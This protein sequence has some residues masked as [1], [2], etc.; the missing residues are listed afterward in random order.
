MGS[1]DEAAT[2]A[3]TSTFKAKVAA[4][5][6][7]KQGRGSMPFVAPLPPEGSAPCAGEENPHFR[8]CFDTRLNTT[9]L[10]VS[11]GVALAGVGVWVALGLPGQLA[12]SAGG[13][14]G[15]LG[16]GL[17]GLVPGLALNLY[18]QGR[19]QRALCRGEVAWLGLLAFPVEGYVEALSTAPTL[20]AERRL[21]FEVTFKGQAPT[22]PLG[23]DLQTLTPR[24]IK[25]AMEGGKLVLEGEVPPPIAASEGTSGLTNA[26]ARN[27]LREGLMELL[28]P[29]HE[30]FPLEAVKVLVLARTK[31]LA[32]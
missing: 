23:E 24:P 25:V 16:L 31:P 14:S 21:A 11:V 12:W 26:P 15:T 27:W 7:R 3:P 19:R 1:H 22:T 17:A 29:L 8:D 28:E 13:A 5:L 18:L 2:S 20:L 30:A 9:D 10:A 4:A 6:E 32:P